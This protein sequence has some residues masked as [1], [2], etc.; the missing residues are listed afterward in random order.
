MPR[1]YVNRNAQASGDHEV[2]QT[3][4][5]YLPDEQNRLYLGVF[6]SCAPAVREAKKT[7]VRSNGC[8]FC[9]RPC[10]TS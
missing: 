8:Y 5:S 3:G 1:Y 10:H 4:C 6:M 7:Y 2:H 9:S